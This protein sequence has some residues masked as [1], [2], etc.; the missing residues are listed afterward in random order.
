MPFLAACILYGLQDRPGAAAV[1]AVAA[2]LCRADLALVLVATAVIA[3][4]RARVS[5]LVVGAV[6]AVVSAVVP[7]RFGDT[8][9]WAPHFASWH[10]NRVLVFESDVERARELLGE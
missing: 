3:R 4:P 5:L 9:G 6:A 7:G 2:T 8:N 1:A 10:G